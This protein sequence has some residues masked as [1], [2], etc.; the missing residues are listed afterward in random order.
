MR[1]IKINKLFPNLFLKN[2]DFYLI[3]FL[4]FLFSIIFVLFSGATWG[5]FNF[6]SFINFY[7]IQVE[8]LMQGH[9]ALSPHIQAMQFDLAWYDGGVQQIWGLGVPLWILPF[10]GVCSIFGYCCS[11]LIPLMTALGLLVF[12]TLQ[13]SRLLLQK[14]QPTPV[15]FLFSGIV[16]FLPTLWIFFWG[17]K[18]IYEIACLYA[19]IFCLILMVATIRYVIARRNFDFFL[20]CFLAGFVANVRP[21]YGVYGVAA[22]CICLWHSLYPWRS[23]R[24][25]GDLKKTFIGSTLTLGGFL[26]LAWSNWFRFGSPFEFGHNLSFSASTIIYLTR[27]G[28]PCDEASFWTLARELFFWL[29]TIPY[30]TSLE[31]PIPRW[32]DTYQPTFGLTYLTLLILSGVL[33]V[34]FA[35]MCK[36]A[37]RLHPHSANNLSSHSAG[38]TP[39]WRYVLVNSLVFWFAISFV[40]LSLFYLKFATLSTRYIHDFAPSFLAATF[41]LLFCVRTASGRWKKFCYGG[42][43]A[44]ICW[45]LIYLMASPA[46]ND[47]WLKWPGGIR[48]VPQ[49]EW[50]KMSEFS[51]IYS[52]D[53]FPE[54][55]GI[56]G[57]GMGWQAKSGQAGSIVTLMVDRPQF[58]ELTLGP[59]AEGFPK[60][61]RARINNIELPLTGITPT[62]Y[63]T[64]TAKCV[65]FSIPESIL[66]QNG[67]QLISLCFTPSFHGRDMKRTRP[68]Y[69][70]R[71]K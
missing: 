68:L 65:R 7:R 32:R 4:T 46:S 66:R 17:P 3:F 23:R 29:F 12:Y 60:V 53:S 2:N 9:F 48:S 40:P 50:K 16:F 11:D 63:G 47:P 24:K 18:G 54:S 64:N 61:Y 51:G 34:R 26:F 15:V 37:G 36:R 45:K 33:L 1:N 10:E 5:K 19:L 62:T 52:L 27:F 49:T 21:T 70:V 57:N 6:P 22:G 35:T 71:W 14:K 28:N 39:S 20:A 56:E 44:F 8:S 55:T 42:L 69:Q 31:A 13:T 38:Q 41:C 59:E 67:N 58:L 43:Y 25:I 30:W